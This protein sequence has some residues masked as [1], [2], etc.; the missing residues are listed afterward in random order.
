MDYKGTT[1]TLGWH[2][3]RVV[4]RSI[5]SGGACHGSIV[6]VAGV[7]SSSPPRDENPQA[8]FVGTEDGENQ[9][10]ISVSRAR[11]TLW[12]FQYVL[13]SDRDWCCCIPGMSGGSQVRL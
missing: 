3:T 9:R 5:P 10:S 6:T 8:E 1:A 7:S 12:S 2:V 13:I 4:D 11:S